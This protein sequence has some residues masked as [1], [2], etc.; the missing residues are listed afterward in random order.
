MGFLG[1]L[2][3]FESKLPHLASDTNAAKNLESMK[4]PLEEL[5][6]KVPDKMEVI[7]AED[8]AYVFIGKPPKSFGMAW[9]EEGKVC[10]FK[11]LSEEKAVSQQQIVKMVDALTEA[12][13]RSDSE[14]RF[15]A[16]IGETNVTVTPSPDL[17]K[18]VRN[19]IGNA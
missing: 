13:K 18:E 10:N 15:S 2:F 1:K 8:R 11:T 5:T 12:Y 7:P 3:G 17:A 4:G 16:Q 9:I 6:K 19:I 14:N